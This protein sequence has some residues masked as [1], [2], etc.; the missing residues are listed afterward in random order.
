MFIFAFTIFLSAFLLFQ[1]QP[2]IAK[3]I[4][5]WFGGSASVWITSMLFFQTA[6]LFGYLYAHWSVRKL[7]PWVQAAV[8]S[9][10]LFVS[11]FL[12]PAQPSPAWKPTG[13][14]DPI[15]RILGLLTV[16]IGLPYF[17]LSTTSPLIQAW[18][19]R[20]YKTSL[21]YKLFGLSNLASLL[22]LL[23]YPVLIEPNVTLRLQSLGW[24][25]AFAVFVALGIAAAFLSR[26]DDAD[27]AYKAEGPP[28]AAG[29]DHVPPR[30]REQLLW[31]LLAA[32]AST[33]LLS[34]TNHLT[35]NIASIP[36][37][38]VLPLSLYLL[39]FILAFDFERAYNR[40]V[41]SWLMTIALAAMA[42]GLVQ[43]NSRTNLKLVIPT[44]LSGLFLV[45]MFCHGELVRRKPAPRHLT[46]FYLMISIGGA[47]GGLLVGLAAPRV[48]PA[49]FELPITLILCSVLLLL[50]LEYRGSRILPVLSWVAA[51]AVFAASGYY[52]T[53]YGKEARVM[54]RNFYGG[55][56]VTEHDT[57]TK[58]EVRMLVHGTVTHGV[59][60]TALNRRRTPISYY[61]RES[62]VS[63]AAKYLRGSTLRVGVIGLGAGSLAA[64][65][66]HG[67]VFR[68]YEINPLVEQMARSEFTYLA[69]CPGKVDVVLGDGRLSLEREPDRSYD[70]L[71]I[72]AF[73]GDAIPVHLLTK[74]ALELYFRRLEPNGILALHITN[75]HLD[76]EP[77]VGKLASALGKHALLVETDNDEEKKIYRS[78]WALL[79][80]RPVNDP[81]ILGK[82]RA[83][84]DRPDL[85]LW[86][87]DYNNL[88]QILK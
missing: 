54:A 42:Y 38:W 61:G 56:R 41:F 13:H 45:C 8:H 58:D 6:L 27:A 16:S 23:A 53:V 48:L 73:S 46:S 20:T 52:L 25:T 47:L 51:A 43:W 57:G 28:D 22:G 62:G 69:D 75:S 85:R 33:L 59:Q 19:A 5:P 82:A 35:Q 67:D 37:L 9:G 12:L 44:F 76:I 2:M 39:T 32:C 10:L 66:R 77:V 30:L 26:R 68:F 17:L 87:D 60:Y 15:L 31:V 7:K 65:A 86:T 11:L 74:Q 72:D 70:L 49:Y 83:L 84:K 64:Y 21:P 81:E 79:S 24:S 36:F 18:Y 71:V 50:V 34:I 55:L 1:I 88:F 4:L 3:M 29:G 78:Q 80:T 63:L 40:K 14:E